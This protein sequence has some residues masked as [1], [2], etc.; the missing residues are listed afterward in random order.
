MSLLIDEGIVEDHGR[1]LGKER[2]RLILEFRETQKPT[3]AVSHATAFDPLAADPI[4]G[5][6]SAQLTRIERTDL[7][8]RV[9]LA[10]GV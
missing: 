9:V 1:V 7:H 2:H 8:G 5:L 3:A 10:A 4:G 6:P